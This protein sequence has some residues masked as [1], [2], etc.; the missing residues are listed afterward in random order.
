MLPLIEYRNVTVQRNGCTALEDISFV[1]GAQERVAILGPNGSGKSTLIKTLTRDL[2]PLARAGSFLRI[3]G[4][5]IWNVFN[6]RTLLGVVSNDLMAGAYRSWTIREIVLSGFFGTIGV[7]PNL[8]VTPDMIRKADELMEHLEIS[9]L[10][11]HNVDEVSSGE[12]RR[13]LIARALVND[14]RALLLDEPTNSLDFTAVRNLRAILGRL[15]RNG[16]GLILV[17]HHLDDII[18]EVDRIILLNRGRVVGDG[19][20]HQILTSECLCALYGMEIEIRE[21]NGLYHCW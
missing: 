14:P 7:W 6:L 8:K 21:R 9:H 17:T 20:K 16:T 13:A 19:P 4:R 15:A 10:A 3:Y 1:I 2:Y 5:E 12:A 11:D 18:P